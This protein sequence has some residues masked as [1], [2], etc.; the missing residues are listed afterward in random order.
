MFFFV[1]IPGQ[2]Q[3]G[4]CSGARRGP[5]IPVPAFKAKA[6]LGA[7]HVFHVASVIYVMTSNHYAMAYGHEYKLG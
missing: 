4:R 7:Q 5:R 3:D 2:K 1:I 6:T